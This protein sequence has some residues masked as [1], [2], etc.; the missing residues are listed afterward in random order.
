MHKQLLCSCSF[1][2]TEKLKDPLLPVCF[3]VATAASLYMA[4]VSV[5]PLKPLNTLPTAKILT[6]PSK[7]QVKCSRMVLLILSSLC[8]PWRDERPL[9]VGG[10]CPNAWFSLLQKTVL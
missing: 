4:V 1:V 6:C 10:G 9:E 5:Q 7:T 8:S 2:Q 3:P